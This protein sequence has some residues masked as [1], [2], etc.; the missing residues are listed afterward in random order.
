MSLIL[1]QKLFDFGVRAS[2]LFA[3]EFTGECSFEPGET[4]APT[5]FMGDAFQ[6]PPVDARNC[7]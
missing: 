1:P 6:D 7:G 3:P 4:V 2:P 5:L